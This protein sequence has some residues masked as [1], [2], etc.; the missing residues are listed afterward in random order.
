M[1]DNLTLPA[2][3][4]PLVDER[5]LIT[6]EWLQVINGLYRRAGGFEG[7]SNQELS[8]EA[9]TLQ[10]HDELLERIGAAEAQARGQPESSLLQELLSR[11]SSLESSNRA[12]SQQVQML[13]FGQMEQPPAQARPPADTLDRLTVNGQT[14]LAV[15]NGK[16]IVGATTAAGDALLHVQ[17]KVNATAYKV[18][19]T[20]VVGARSA[21]I[22][23][24]AAYAGQTVGAT[25]AQAQ[26]QATDN[27]TKAASAKLA[28]IVTALRTHGLIGD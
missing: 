10:S 12:L 4:V 2:A 14:N 7:F 19:D 25:Y 26:A 22:T 9:A 6:R 3:R 23:A 13:A 18:A 15:R 20:Q 16:V 17:G 24:Y 28:Q 1:S 11:I 27:A 5:G 21:G 8:G